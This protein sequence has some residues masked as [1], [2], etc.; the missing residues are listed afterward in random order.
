[1]RWLTAVSM[2]VLAGCASLSPPPLPT[3][4]ATT[5]HYAPR[6]ER[7]WLMPQPVDEITLFDSRMWQARRHWED[8]QTLNANGDVKVGMWIGIGF[9]AALGLVAADRVKDATDDLAE[10]AADNFFECVFDVLFG[11]DCDDED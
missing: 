10:D 3:T 2:A 8:S 9:G 4:A 7:P 1:M 11:G 5:V 6:N